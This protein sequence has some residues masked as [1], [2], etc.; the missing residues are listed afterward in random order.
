MAG[1]LHEWLSLVFF[2]YNYTFMDFNIVVF[3]FMNIILGLT[4]TSPHLWVAG[5]NL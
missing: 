2:K 4:F 5:G 3:Q 1:L